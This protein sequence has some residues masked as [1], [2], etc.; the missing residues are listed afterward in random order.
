MP[1]SKHVGNIHS[2]SP[3]ASVH[4]SSF[5]WFT[6]L[7]YGR[8]QQSLFIMWRHLLG[9]CA[10]SKYKNTT[11]ANWYEKY[12]LFRWTASEMCQYVLQQNKWDHQDAFCLQLLALWE[13]RQTSIKL[14]YND[15]LGMSIRHYVLF[16][17]LC[18]VQVHGR[19]YNINTWCA[20]P[21]WNN[22]LQILQGWS[23]SRI[24]LLVFVFRPRG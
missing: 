4:M 18:K 6:L 9:E 8:Q 17:H 1:L 20:L 14:E 16:F 15:F 11:A 7:Q 23:A 12:F 2:A 19:N 3:S 13:G 5:L 22:E 24:R 10:M 21:G